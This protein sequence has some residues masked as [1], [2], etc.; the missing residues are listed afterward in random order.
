MIRPYRPYRHGE[1][2]A[3]PSYGKFF[4]IAGSLVF[5]LRVF[6]YQL[7][8]ESAAAALLG[9][10]IMCLV[11]YLFGNKK[12]FLQQNSRCFIWMLPVIYIVVNCGLIGRFTWALALLLTS[13]TALI[14]LSCGT[15]W[16]EV[17]HHVMVA[18]LAVFAVATVILFLFPG[19][20]PSIKTAFFIGY[21][22]ATDYHSGLTSHYSANGSFMALGLVLCTPSLMFAEGGLKKN[23]LWLALTMLFLFALLLTAKRGPLLSAIVAL[24]FAFLVSDPKGKFSKLIVPLTVIACG[25][26]ILVTLVPQVG[27]V[28][29]RFSSLSDGSS[30]EDT[31]SGRIYLWAQALD[32]WEAN[33]LFGIGWGRFVYT[34]SRNGLTVTLAHNEL[35]DILAT[36]GVF[37]TVFLIV[38]ELYSLFFT[39]K[40]AKSIPSGSSIGVYLYIS[41]AVQTLTLVYGYSSGGI[42][43]LIYISVPYILSIAVPFAIANCEVQNSLYE[44]EASYDHLI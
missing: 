33:P 19:L 30:L 15:D 11:V 32:D 3:L 12:R 38:T 41:L 40:L 35:L 8:S 6:A 29:D 42:I 4:L 26:L 43:P 36:L 24:L 7:I 9:L 27:E 21:H 23:K 18:I 20:Y 10:S 39:I 44:K 16:I 22:G 28:F 17:G 14:I 1:E 34:F 31:T 5:L 25:T 37:G 2:R 13:V